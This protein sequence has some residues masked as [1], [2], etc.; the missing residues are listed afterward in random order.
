MQLVA[1]EKNKGLIVIIDTSLSRMDLIR[2][3]SRILDDV[4]RV[5]YYEI[6]NVRK[7]GLVSRRLPLSRAIRKILRVIVRK[8]HV[9]AL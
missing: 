8:L 2:L 3:D 7:H 9:R 5:R 4:S 6:L 1:R